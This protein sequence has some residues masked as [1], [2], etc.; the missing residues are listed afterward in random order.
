MN[1]LSWLIVIVP[2]VY[3]MWMAFYSRRYVRD[4]TDYLA[5][6][7]VAGRYVISVGDMAAGLSVITLVALSEKD[8]QTGMAIGFWN[9]LSTPVGLFM[10]LGGYC[11]YRFRQ[12][13]CLSA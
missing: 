5:S 2:L 1:T 10:A 7:R 11:V 6:G 4:I 13:R 3:V 9:Q 8:Y 12:T